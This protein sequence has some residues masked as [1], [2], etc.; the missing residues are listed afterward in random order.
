MRTHWP[1]LN[2]KEDGRLNWMQMMSA[3][4]GITRHDTTTEHNQATKDTR[5]SYAYHLKLFYEDL[6]QLK[7]EAHVIHIDEA[8]VDYM[9]LL[10][11]LQ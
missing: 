4:W 8:Y 2:L 10:L 3:T 11:Q 7:K 9:G 6:L 5:Q 1:D